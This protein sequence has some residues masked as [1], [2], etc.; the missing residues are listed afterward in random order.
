ME[1]EGTKKEDTRKKCWMFD[2]KGLVHSNRPRLEEFKKVYAHEINSD[3]DSNS[4]LACIKKIKPTA[5]VGVSTCPKLFTKEV[6]AE[7][8]AINQQPLILALSNPTS[9]EE[10]SAEDA[11]NYTNG[12][13]LFA[14]GVKFDN[15]IIN[16]KTYYPTQAN[17]LWIF[18]AIGM[19]V[20]ATKSKKVTEKMFLVAAKALS[21]L[22]S[23]ERLEKEA[24]FPDEK[25]IIIIT[26]K[27]A[28]AVALFIFDNNF[29][30]VKRPDYDDHIIHLIEKTSY[31]PFYQNYTN[32]K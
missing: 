19:A 10:C 2:T 18:P 27:V 31:H 32:G 30:S 7:M 6:L 28:A 24:L 9:Q 13:A 4:F 26:S 3:F 23:E 25:D 16:K 14:A 17:N 12:K 1:E 15:V 8:A 11:Y 20:Y 21:E 22:V 29:A 5:I